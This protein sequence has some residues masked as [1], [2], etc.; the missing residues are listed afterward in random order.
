MKKFKNKSDRDLIIPD[1][2]I[3]KAGEIVE[4]PDGFHNA[5]FEPVKPTREKAAEGK[6][7]NKND[8]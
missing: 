8:E 7:S 2:G 1:V 4:L 5:N 6:E 3:V